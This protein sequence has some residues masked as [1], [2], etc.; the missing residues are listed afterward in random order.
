M[1]AF[2][3]VDQE[4][5]VA[6]GRSAHDRLGGDIAAGTWPVLD[7]ELLAEPLRQ[8]LAHQTRDDVGRAAGAKAD[9]DRT[10]RVG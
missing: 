1:I 6:V 8:P 7:D 5:R 9:D 10:G 4:Q 3:S 2:V